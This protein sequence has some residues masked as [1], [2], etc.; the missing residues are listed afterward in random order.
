MFLR[1]VWKLAFRLALLVTAVILYISDVDKL[2]FTAVFRMDLYWAFL[3]VIWVTLV[4]DMLYRLLP[5]KRIAMGARKHFF[6]SY[7]AAP[8]DGAD[9][10]ALHKKAHK[11]AFLSAVSWAAVSAAALFILHLLNMLT[12]AVV[13]LIMLFYAVLDLVFILFFCP[14]QVLFMRNGCCS[15]CRIYNWD[16]IMMCM[17]MVLFPGVYSISLF[18]LSL[19][20]LIRWEIALFTKPYYFLRETNENLTCEL[21]EDRLCLIR[22]MKQ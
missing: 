19:A 6:C 2:N 7:N 13:V 12:P 11:G 8:S 15:L 5:N 4:I 1:H 9:T 17:P 3:F 18:I 16:Y 14:F 22:S 21:C 20:V 10:S